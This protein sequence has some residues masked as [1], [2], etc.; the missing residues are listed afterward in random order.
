MKKNAL[1]GLLSERPPSGPPRLATGQFRRRPEKFYTLRKRGIQALGGP[2][3]AESTQSRA[4]RRRRSARCVSV[5]FTIQ[6]P[7]RICKRTVRF[8]AP[9]LPRPKPAE[10]LDCP[11]SCEVKFPIGAAGLVVLKRFRTEREN[12]RL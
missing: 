12:V 11:N 5:R 1:V 4:C 10:A 8:P 9:E 3:P 7:K 6:K 2:A